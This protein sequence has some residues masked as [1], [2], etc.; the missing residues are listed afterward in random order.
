MT[1]R[2]RIFAGPNGSGKTTIT[3]IVKE[4]VNL[5][6]YV[7]ADD[8]KS[9]LSTKR[10]L[11]FK[12]Y[13]LPL[14]K[15]LFIDTLKHSSFVP[16]L[17]DVDLVLSHL[18]FANTVLTI[19]EDTAVD[20]YFVSFIADYLRT[21]LLETSSKFTIETVMSHPSKLEFIKSA[22]DK[23]FKVYLYFVSLVDPQ[24]NIRREISKHVE[25]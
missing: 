20:D 16:R 18:D 12:D 3:N 25:H 4:Y 13:G 6:V 21:E 17:A 19:K 2:L 8:I 9:Q 24:L 10:K 5:G 22:K 14:N 11:D 1:K 7:N 23:G 15:Q